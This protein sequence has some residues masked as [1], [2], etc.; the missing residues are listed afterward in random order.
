VTD[1]KNRSAQD[2]R[3]LLNKNHGSFADAGSVSYQFT[4]RGEI[5]LPAST[6]DEDT[7]T[8]LALECGADDVTSDGEDWIFYTPTDQLFHVGTA[9]K[10]QGHEPASQNLIYQASNVL[11]LSDLETAR[12]VIHLHDLLSDYDDTQNVYSNFDIDDSIADLLDS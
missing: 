12:Q 8:M 9:L 4:R 10:E 6:M 11:V 3:A 2:L 7:A 1:N 5:R